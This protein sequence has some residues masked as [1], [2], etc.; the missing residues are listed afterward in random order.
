MSKLT[1]KMD[2]LQQRINVFT[3]FQ[4]DDVLRDFDEGNISDLFFRDIIVYLNK[5]KTKCLTVIILDSSG[6][7]I[8]LIEENTKGG[9]PT[10][11]TK[12]LSFEET[13]ILVKT[14]LRG[15]KIKK[16]QHG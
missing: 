13:V 15:Y 6:T 8:Q 9:N 1:D 5:E 2:E 3:I 14:I 16:L 4:L 12:N 7:S 10:F 11:L